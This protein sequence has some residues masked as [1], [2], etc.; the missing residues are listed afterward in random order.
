MRDLHIWGLHHIY[1]CTCIKIYTI[2][3]NIQK[4]YLSTMEYEYINILW[5]KDKYCDTI[6]YKSSGTWQ[7]CRWQHRLSKIITKYMYWI[8]ITLYINALTTT[9]IVHQQILWFVKLL[10]RFWLLQG[11]KT[12]ALFWNDYNS[13]I[14]VYI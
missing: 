9:L 7:V 2:T 14:Q 10:Q 5:I 8:N 4:T 12:T 3:V 6:W 13:N 11:K 1:K